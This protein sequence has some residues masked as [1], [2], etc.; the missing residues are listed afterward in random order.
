MRGTIESCWPRFVVG[1]SYV[2]L[3]CLT[4]SSTVPVVPCKLMMR[5]YCELLLFAFCFIVF[6]SCFRLDY[7]LLDA[8]IQGFAFSF[9]DVFFSFFFSFLFFFLF[10]FLFH[11]LLCYH[12]MRYFVW[13]ICTET[14]ALPS[15]YFFVVCFSESR[16]LVFLLLFLS[17]V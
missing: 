8:L 5:R 1:R 9:N 2:S 3:L 17:V 15:I 10:Q 14:N 16:I 7:I 4:S 13:C 12:C 11:S 6:P